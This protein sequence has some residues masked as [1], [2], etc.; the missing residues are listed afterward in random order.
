MNCDLE[1]VEQVKEAEELLAAAWNCSDS[2]EYDRLVEQAE[3]LL[4]PLVEC[5]I[6]H[7]QYGFM[8]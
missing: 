7:A 5:Q 6:P 3:K 8:A 1:Y 2:D 4:V